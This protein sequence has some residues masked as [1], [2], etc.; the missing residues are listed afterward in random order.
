M[1]DYPKIVDPTGA[2]L[3]QWRVN[4]YPPSLPPS[5]KT[6]AALAENDGALQGRSISSKC[7][8]FLADAIR[9]MSRSSITV[10]FH[11]IF[12]LPLLLFSGSSAPNL[13]LVSPN[14]SSLYLARCQTHR[15]TSPPSSLPDDVCHLSPKRIFS[16]FFFFNFWCTASSFSWWRL[17][18]VQRWTNR[19][20]VDIIFL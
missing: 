6:S 12:G 2:F 11:L 10:V 5:D 9:N 14:A 1:S 4:S 8:S 19:L 7:C 3:D 18:G 15:P 17:W 13:R 16:E 20:F